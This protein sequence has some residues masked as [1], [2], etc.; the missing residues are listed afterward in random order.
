VTQRCEDLRFTLESRNPIK[1]A[2]KH[3]GQT[4]DRESRFNFVSRAR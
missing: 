3:V 1:I 4:F 2:C